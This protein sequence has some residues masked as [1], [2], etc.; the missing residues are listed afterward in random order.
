[1]E[2]NITTNEA[3]GFYKLNWLQRIRFGSGDMAQN[4]IY[5]T[6]SIWLLFFYTNVYGLNPGTAALMFLVVR[7]VDVLWDPI[8][9][10]FVDKGNPRWGKYRSWLIL[11]GIPLVGLSILCFWNGFIAAHGG[12]NGLR[13]LQNRLQVDI[14]FF[15][16][17]FT[18]K[19]NGLGGDDRHHPA[20]LRVVRV[21]G[22]GEGDRQVQQRVCAGDR[23]SDQDLPAHFSD[24]ERVLRLQA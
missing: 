5:Q 15:V 12:H 22:S 20:Q 9:G 18:G 6:I 3:K 13:F 1:M 21:E 8:V 17:G 14:C 19:A 4:L 24:H 10:T 23:V 16:R 2:T 7:L 11:G